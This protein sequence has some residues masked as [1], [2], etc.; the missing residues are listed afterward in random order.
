M[1]NKTKKEIPNS[2]A[3]PERVAKLENGLDVSP[4]PAGYVVPQELTEDRKWVGRR[5]MR[6]QLTEHLG[7]EGHSSTRF[8][9]ML[10]LRA[11]NEEVEEWM[12]VEEAMRAA[13]EWEARKRSEKH[14]TGH[15]AVKKFRLDHPLPAEFWRI[16][17]S[18]GLI[19][20][21]Q[22]H[23]HKLKLP[24]NIGRIKFPELIERLQSEVECYG[25]NMLFELQAN[26]EQALACVK[27]VAWLL[28]NGL[29]LA[30]AVEHDI[31]CEAVAAPAEEEQTEAPAPARKTGMGSGR[32]DGFEDEAVPQM[33]GRQSQTGA[34]NSEALAAR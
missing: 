21:C 14:P 18:D 13:E 20:D 6:E 8:V 34:R 3:L 31:G 4:T 32:K 17:Y 9:R 24:A 11:M 27:L 16:N 12:E 5:W 7:R 10:K 2:A 25:M 26:A 19:A 28:G 23:D 1:K 29:D 15:K 22:E 30:Q 33:G